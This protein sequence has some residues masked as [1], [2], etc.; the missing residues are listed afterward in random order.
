MN[1]ASYRR[2][3][4]GWK[5]S[6]RGWCV[7]GDGSIWKARGLSMW[8]RDA[9]GFG[10]GCLDALGERAKS[11]W[12]ISDSVSGRLQGDAPS[13]VRGLAGDHPTVNTVLGTVN[14]NSCASRLSKER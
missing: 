4:L 10:V 2:T 12:W 13:A 11:R 9:S 6:G 14:V 5:T 1:N 8:D 3:I 7:R